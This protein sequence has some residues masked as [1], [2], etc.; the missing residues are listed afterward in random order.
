MRED[1]EANNLSELSIV[2]KSLIKDIV[3]NYDFNSL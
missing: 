2:N 3:D 1:K